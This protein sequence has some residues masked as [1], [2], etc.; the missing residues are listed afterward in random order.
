MTKGVFAFMSPSFGPVRQITSAFAET[1]KLLLSDPE[2]EKMIYFQSILDELK[3]IAQS[4]QTHFPELS[5]SARDKSVRTILAEGG[6]CI[7][8]GILCPS[9]ILTLLAGCNQGQE[10]SSRDSISSNYFEYH[11]DANDRIVAAHHFDAAYSLIEPDFVE[12]VLRQNEVEYGITFHKGWHEVSY[13]SKSVYR[14][15]QIQNY[16]A[17]DYDEAHPDEMYLHYEEF[18][19]ADDIPIKV[20]VYFGISPKLDM[21]EQD[22]FEIVFDDVNSARE[23]NFN[24]LSL[25]FKLT[26]E[27]RER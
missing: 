25:D 11:F 5:N 23:N 26:K 15:G 9:P 3:Q 14:D 22:T 8:R 7:H 1:M 18:Q 6:D 19:Y 4:H 13:I 27:R 16:A 12:F 2:S 17:A 20:D 24:A 10:A 21:Y